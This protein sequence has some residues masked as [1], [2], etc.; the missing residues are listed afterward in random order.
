[1]NLVLKRKRQWLYEIDPRIKLLWLLSYGIV[2]FTDN[3]FL[4]SIACVVAITVFILVEAHRSIYRHG[5]IIMLSFLVITGVFFWVRYLIYL[6]TKELIVG[7]LMILK[8]LS[9]ILSSI[10]FFVMSSPYEIGFALQS[11]RVPK[12]AAFSVGIGFRFIPIVLNEFYMTLLAQ[13]A[14]GLNAE[15]GIRSLIK[16][17]L[18]LRSITIPLLRTL[19]KKMDNMSVLLSLRGID[20]KGYLFREENKF[21]VMDFLIFSYSIILI[22]FSIIMD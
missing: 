8:W 1:M 5:F 11:L 18:I 20:V 16:I 6:N 4:L 10:A 13:K 2:F 9:I 22:I 17:P 21:R 15:R 12:I 3:V 7:S 19:I 14:R